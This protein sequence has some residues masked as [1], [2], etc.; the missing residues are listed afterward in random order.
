MIEVVIKK[1]ALCVQA[2]SCLVLILLWDSTF[3]IYRICSFCNDF[4]GKALG[5]SQ[6]DL[7]LTLFGAVQKEWVPLNLN[8]Q[9]W[10][11]E[12]F[13]FSPLT[14]GKQGTQSLY[15]FPEVTQGVSDRV[16]NWIQILRLSAPLCVLLQCRAV[17]WF[18]AIF[19]GKKKKKVISLN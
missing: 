18:N 3:Q 15:K 5:P 13:F 14:K 10:E 12:R 17:Q 7:G 8:R 2:Q 1:T 4:Y 6:R 9:T 19:R 11:T 16:T